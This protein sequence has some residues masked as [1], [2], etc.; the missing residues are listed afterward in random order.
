MAGRRQESHRGQEGTGNSKARATG[1][2]HAQHACTIWGEALVESKQEQGSHSENPREKLCPGRPPDIALP[3]RPAEWTPLPKRP[4]NPASS[5]SP[6]SQLNCC[7]RLPASTPA[8]PQNVPYSASRVT[9]K[10]KQKQ[11][12]DCVSGLKLTTV[13]RGIS[14]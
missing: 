5:S 9:F 14:G 7:T 6:T 3:T 13:F 10:K 8:P 12:P 2:G 11:S 1:A 4:P